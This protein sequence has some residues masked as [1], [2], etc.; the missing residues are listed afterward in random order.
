AMSALAASCLAGVLI[1]AG[2]VET[3]VAWA[4]GALEDAV[5]VG[6]EALVVS[7]LAL[8]ASGLLP[9][10]AEAAARLAGWCDSARQRLNLRTRPSEALARRVLDRALGALLDA[11]RLRALA[12]EGAALCEAEAIGL[13][14][15][16][17]M[18]AGAG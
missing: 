8:V 6:E 15:H 16:W 18:P 13:V 11:D 10:S 7:A 14:R 1:A 2:E 5:A 4:R 17:P 12:D 9:G 3:G